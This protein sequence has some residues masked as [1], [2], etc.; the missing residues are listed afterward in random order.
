MS[1]ST[2]DYLPSL[3]EDRGPGFLK[4]NW[5][6]V[7]FGV[8]FVGARIFTRLRVLRHLSLDDYLMLTSL[9]SKDLFERSHCH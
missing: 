8:L 1:M 9:V 6:G 4:A 5:I 7:G 2:M 3:T